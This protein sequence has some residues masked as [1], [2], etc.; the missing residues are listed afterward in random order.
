M[1]EES[2]DMTFFHEK[3]TQ[4]DLNPNRGLHM[5]SAGML[6]KFMLIVTLARRPQILILDEPTSGVDPVSRI[7]MLDLIQEFM[8]NENHTVLFSMHITSD[9]D[10]IADYIVLTEKGKILFI[11]EKEE[12][13]AAYKTGDVLPTMEEIM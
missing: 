12:L 11:K 1:F 7:E 2:F 8:E 5:Y 6:K 9:L 10:K 13:K 3:M 4:L